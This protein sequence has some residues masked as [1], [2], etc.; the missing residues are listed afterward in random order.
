M[1][2]WARSLGRPG[3]VGLAVS[4]LPSRPGRVDFT[5]SA[6]LAVLR[7]R[8]AVAGCPQSASS[9][10]LAVSPWPYNNNACSPRFDPR[11]LESLDHEEFD[12]AVNESTKA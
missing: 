12:L 7:G 3:R 2:N 11:R 4:P 10:A 9:I 6:G 5:V 1:E 8:I